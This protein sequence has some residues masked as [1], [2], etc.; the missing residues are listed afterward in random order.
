M[1]SQFSISLVEKD[2]TAGFLL[3]DIY[4]LFMVIKPHHI[5]TKFSP[6]IK[7]GEP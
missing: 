3:D 1:P 6:S 4:G 5:L 7:L 2:V